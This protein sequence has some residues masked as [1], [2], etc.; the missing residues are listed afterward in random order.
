MKT[1]VLIPGYMCDDQIW[2]NQIVRLKKKYK[3]II[4][5]LKRGNTIKEFSSRTLKLLPKKFSIVGFSMGGFVALDLAINY[6]KRVED[7]IL[8][9]TNARGV[10]KDRRRLLKKSEQELNNKNYIERFSQ[11]SFESYIGKNN[12]KNKSYLKLINSMV[13]NHSF[14]C[15]KRQTNAILTRP[16]QLNKLS[17]ITARCMIIVGSDDKLSSKEM[18]TELN[19]NISGSELFY[20]KQSGHFVM[21]EQSKK[22]NQLLFKWLGF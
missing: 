19:K 15:L 1:I 17:K 18:N 21:I 3:V 11:S 10:S 16:S 4:P 20:I 9:G 8:V 22:F 7:L 5:S 12:K 14:L 6:S 13:R 2:I